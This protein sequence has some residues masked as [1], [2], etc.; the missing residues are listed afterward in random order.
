M[1]ALLA[2]LARQGR[3]V[4]RLL[5]AESLREGLGV[6]EA[7]YLLGEAVRFCLIPG[8]SGAVGPEALAGML[9]QEPLLGAGVLVTRAPHQ[10]RAM[11]ERIEAMGGRPIAF[12][13]NETAD[14]L[15]W[16]PLDQALDIIG[17]Y[18]WLVIT[19]PN[20]AE[21][22]SRRLQARGL[23]P[24]ALAHLKVAAV[25]RGTARRLEE[26]GL[27]VD[28]IPG[29]ARGAALPGAL[30]PLLRKGDRILMA[31]GDLAD[32]GP[33]QALRALGCAV[34]D[35][36]AYRTVPARDDPAPVRQALRLGLV[37][38]VTFTATST[39]TGLLSLLGGADAL[40]G[41]RVAVIGP[42]T[43]RGAEEAGLRVDLIAPEASPEALVGVISADRL[44]RLG[45]ERLEL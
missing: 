27:Q 45:R 14:P 40:A 20:G 7:A 39:V 34:D 22:F 32:P 24:R 38:Y 42:E 33:A 25:G 11:V 10:A 44:A 17:Q 3:T 21:R 31:R 8:Q 16:A 18:A 1:G 29:E 19:S 41:T 13:V 35:L 23:T 43:K 15:D 6:R 5:P 28:L 26:L 36:V 4:C 9:R 2:D 12:A 37:D 30:A